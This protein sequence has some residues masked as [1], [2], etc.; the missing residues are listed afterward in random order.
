M[1]GK[2]ASEN[3]TPK[4]REFC[5]QY[6]T[7]GDAKA[8]Y[9]AA[10]D[11]NSPNSAG[12]E[13]QKLLRQPKIQAYLDELQKPAQ[14]KAFHERD[15]KRKVLWD[16]INSADSSNADKCRAMDILNK[17]DGEYANLNRP[18]DETATDIS[19]LDIET[20]KQIAN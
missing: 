2:R 15:K 8:S 14:R 6:I 11:S 12:I 10:Y 20:L 1:I 3:L 7:N 5:H 19:E 18:T 17:L 16:I 4:Q 9:L 13:G